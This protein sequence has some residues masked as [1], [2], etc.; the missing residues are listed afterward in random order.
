MAAPRHVLSRFH[1]CPTKHNTI[2]LIGKRA[3]G[4]TTLGIEIIKK[5]RFKEG[6]VMRGAS[7]EVDLYTDLGEHVIVSDNLDE[8]MLVNICARQRIKIKRA[9][10][11][12]IRQKDSWC[13][14]F[15]DD[16]LCGYNVRRSH[17]LKR[18][19]VNGRC[20]HIFLVMTLQHPMALPPVLRTNIGVSFHLPHQRVIS[21]QRKLWENYA[22]CIE[23]FQSYQE[24]YNLVTNK[25]PYV[26]LVIDNTCRSRVG[27][28]RY[29]G[30]RDYRIDWRRVI[31]KKMILHRMNQR[32]WFPQ[33]IN[34]MLIAMI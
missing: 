28:V 26:N 19:I 11:G 10:N 31:R 21:T 12:E 30:G 17:A 27:S 23:T 3:T 18:I 8:R 9:R 5:C 29:Y 2:V 7:G 14:V 24:I 32:G 16:V 33:E 34:R 1:P 15:L 22:G 25:A 4:K 20:L 13:F 6:Y